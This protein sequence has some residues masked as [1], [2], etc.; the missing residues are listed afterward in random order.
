MPALRGGPVL[1]CFGHDQP[2]QLHPRGLLVRGTR[3]GCLRLPA[4]ITVIS[5]VASS[6]VNSINAV[7]LACLSAI[8]SCSPI[9]SANPI[10]CPNGTLR[11]V[12]ATR[13]SCHSRAV[14][15]A[16]PCAPRCDLWLAANPRRFRCYPYP[17]P[18]LPLCLAG[19]SRA[20]LTSP[21][22]TRAQRAATA[23]ARGSLPPRASAQ[24]ASTAC[25]ALPQPTLASQACSMYLMAGH[26]H[27][28]T[29]G[30]STQ[31]V[32]SFF[33]PLRCASSPVQRRSH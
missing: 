30:A 13:T 2:D 18:C 15:A 19:P 27:P 31:Q 4:Q 6:D 22:A 11:C 26:A 12:A 21:T 8:C 1:P 9:G 29:T 10:P 25:L 5:T 20:A 16:F 32:F 23:A 3:K 24:R 28:D 7:P 17:R 33:C 14:P